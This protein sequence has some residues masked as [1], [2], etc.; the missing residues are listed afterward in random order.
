MF[1]INDAL[2]IKLLF[3]SCHSVLTVC[4]KL[5]TSLINDFLILS[6]CH[7][8]SSI[9]NHHH[10]SHHIFF[11]CA[12]LVWKPSC[13]CMVKGKYNPSLIEKYIPETRGFCDCSS[14]A[15]CC[16]RGLWAEPPSRSRAEAAR[17]E[18][19]C[20]PVMNGVVMGNPGCRPAIASRSP[21]C[22]PDAT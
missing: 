6:L 7:I 1:N 17:Y 18:G 11:R 9:I 3:R 8:L 13:I 16:S 19:R 14:R 2:S 10:Q 12:E 5:H 15:M 4:N 21:S 22:W 20:A